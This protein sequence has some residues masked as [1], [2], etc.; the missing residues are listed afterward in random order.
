[1]IG[2]FDSGV[3]GLSVLRAMAARLPHEALHYVADSAHAPYGE[4]DP[5]FIQARALVLAQHL[6]D[7]GAKAL[8]IACNTASVV[9]AARLR[10]RFALPIVAMEPAIKPAAA[11]TRSG[12]VGVLA[13]SR[14]LASDAVSALCARFPGVRWRLQ[15]CPGLVECIERGETTHPATRGL[16][17]GLVQ[18]LLA[19]GA[20]TLV[21]GCTH[22]PFIAPLL[23][24]ITGPAVHIVDPSDAVARQVA[25]RLPLAATAGTPVH[26]F[27][28]TGDA[29]QAQRVMSRL[30]GRPVPV[31]AASG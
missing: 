23:R 3:G 27:A 5:A 11:L 31:L 4:R 16:L 6:V 29:V 2:V 18:P 24:Q 14:T 7:Q 10:E 13:T 1:M 19:D 26:R 28:S 12:T 30:W 21:L 20:D 15:P 17:Q 9:A 8:V 22:Y 25:A